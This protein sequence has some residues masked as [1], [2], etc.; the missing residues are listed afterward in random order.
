MVGRLSSLFIYPPLI[1]NSLKSIVPGVK[2]TRF[3]SSF[4]SVGLP[5]LS[6][7]FASTLYISLFTNTSTADGA[8]VTSNVPSGFTVV[9]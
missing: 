4:V 6:D 3:R 8:T 5:A 2:S 1:S 7:T 9:V